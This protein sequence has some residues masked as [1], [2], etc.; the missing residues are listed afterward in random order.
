MNGSLYFINECVTLF[1]FKFKFHFWTIS[2]CSATWIVQRFERKWRFSVG[3]LL[4]LYSTDRNAS[5]FVRLY[6]C[7]VRLVR[8]ERIIESEV[9][10][11]MR[12]NFKGKIWSPFKKLPEIVAFWMRAL[13]SIEHNLFQD[14]H[15][16]IIFSYE[17]IN[18][19]R[20][21]YFWLFV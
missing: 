3:I 12:K 5:F 18:W 14:K 2:L 11:S 9:K 17:V 19:L 7:C 10:M 16:Y 8:I 21:I 13:R 6:E 20:E 1:V 15:S 4:L